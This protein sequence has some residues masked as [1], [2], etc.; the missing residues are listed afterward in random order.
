[1]TE[2]PK[3]FHTFENIPLAVVQNLLL[4]HKSSSLA[5]ALK[6]MYP[7]QTFTPYFLRCILVARTYCCNCKGRFHPFI[8]HEA[9]RESRGIGVY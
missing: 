3:F 8:G 6:R 2:K 7:V 5:S 4:V 1:M 9:L